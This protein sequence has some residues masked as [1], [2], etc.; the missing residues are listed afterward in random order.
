[1]TGCFRKHL[2]TMEIFSLAFLFLQEEV[3]HL[4]AREI[5]DGKDKKT[6]QINV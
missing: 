5:R 3:E 2:I 1:M 4:M 6:D